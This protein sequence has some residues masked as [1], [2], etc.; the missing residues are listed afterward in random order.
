MLIAKKKWARLFVG[1]SQIAAIGAKRRSRENRNRVA[2]ISVALYVIRPW[3][4]RSRH[5]LVHER[6]QT[7]LYS[8]HTPSF[9]RT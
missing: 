9:H 7:I 4:L 1:V 2:L 6:S 3:K 8:K 5:V